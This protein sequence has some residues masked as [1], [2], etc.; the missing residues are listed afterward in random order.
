MRACIYREFGSPDVLE[1]VADWPRPACG[2]NEVL[3]KVAAC[4]VNPKDGLLRRGKFRHTLARDPLPRVTGLDLAGTIAE[5]GSEVS[6]FVV[7]DHVF[8]MTNRFSGGVMAEYAA[9]TASEIA[10][11]PDSLSIEHAAAVPLAAQTALQG[12]RDQCQ[13]MPEC[14]VLITGGSGGVGHFAVQIAAVLGAEVHAVC[15]PDNVEFVAALGASRVFDYRKQ[16]PRSIDARYDAI[17]DAAGRY[18]RRDFSRQLT[19]TAVFAAVVPQSRA[20][21]GELMARLR[22]S[23]ASRMVFVHSV[24]EDL[25]WLSR[26]IDAGAISPN[27]DHLFA[28]DQVQAAHEQIQT[29]HTRGKIVVRVPA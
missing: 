23:R 25:I 26:Q 24:R 16:D 4:S 6:D 17:F 5:V 15:G 7:D 9:L 21:L 20:I 10:H 13:V 27:V 2:P 3:V 29:A 28:A 1:W 12:L 18:Q 14:R 19:S 22:L 11:A 8:G